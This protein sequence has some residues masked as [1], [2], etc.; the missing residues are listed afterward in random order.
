MKE[1]EI[2]NFELTYDGM[3]FIAW[4][5]HR[6]RVFLQLNTILKMLEIEGLSY[7]K[8]NEK[9]LSW[10]PIKFSKVTMTVTGEEDHV[11]CL[12]ILTSDM[13]DQYLE[14]KSLIMFDIDLKDCE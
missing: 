10:E 13:S 9:I 7:K 1:I 8:V 12:N 4:K 2:K 3:Y 6:I 11:G 14:K 5:N